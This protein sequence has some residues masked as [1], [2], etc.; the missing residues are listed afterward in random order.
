MTKN[1]KLTL[2][3]TLIL[4]ALFFPINSP[5]SN[6]AYEY[7]LSGKD[8]LDKGD[9]EDAISQL[10][11]AYKKMPGLLDD[12][13]LMWRAE[14]YENRGDIVKALNDINEIKEKYKDSPLI[15]EVRL[16]EIKLLINKNN[17]GVSVLFDS[18]IRDYPSEFD[19]KYAYA[20]FLKENNQ[21]KRAKEIF[22]EIFISAS[23][24]SKNALNRLSPSDIT[25]ED[26]FKRG[27][28]LNNAWFFIE[29]EKYF[30]EAL[31]QK[32]EVR[33][34]R[35]SEEVGSQEAG[36][37]RQ[38]AEIRTQILEGLAYSL[39]RQR[40]Y[41]EA[42]ELYKEMNN[43]FWRARSLF[44]ADDMKGFESELPE[45]KATDDKRF[46]PIF[47]AYGTKKRREGDIEEAL[48]IFNN[49]LSKYPS[50]KEPILWAIGWTHYLS[51]SYKNAH[52]VFFSLH[53]TFGDSK[54]LYWKNRCSEILGKPETIRTPPK[55]HIAHRDFYA[56]LPMFKS[57]P[58]FSITLSDRAQ[59]SELQSTLSAIYNQQ[60][61]FNLPFVTDYIQPPSERVG[62]FIR[63]GFK[64][65][66]IVEL[67]HLS[68]KSPDRDKLIHISSYLK[69]LGEYRK[70][71]RLISR[72]PY[73][74]GFHALL[75]PLAFMAEVENA[76]KKN[77]IDPLLILA[78][79]RE[80]SMLDPNA[81]S[82]AG[83]QGL[84]QLMP[85]TAQRISKYVYPI[86]HPDDLHNPRINILFGAHYL[87]HLID[88]F[89]SI[90]IALAAYNAGGST[91][92]RWLQ[93]GN[94][95]TIDEFIEDIPFRE[96]NTYVKRVLT[97][98]AE[99]M[100]GQ[101]WKH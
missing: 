59:I 65:E 22:K 9:Y 90:P 14:A 64:Q 74:K 60:V 75:Y 83:A 34:S 92:N 30:R 29:A 61:N 101:T 36:V 7:L 25:I 21:P 85:Q 77:N 42:A 70:A 51:E 1:N 88:S 95:N 46:V 84:M 89:N 17:P 23:P 44:R 55:G 27:K 35:K 72:I 15:K 26:I 50:E 81:R 73:N 97:T 3:I 87:S 69:D 56:F 67:I 6:E 41:E 19:I 32:S 39:F 86:K 71:M 28:N 16:K 52:D 40:R 5:A 2:F 4:L 49:L 43:H 76:A 48:K 79:M 45:F 12:Y 100:R 93:R 20:S 24:L 33:R 80:E 58:T 62:I 91:V 11:T 94:Y 98:Y 68:R 10:T 78:V 66:A 38:K 53:K 54:Y 63:L 37:R 82:I 18:F 13:I 8:S 96:T 31:K 57:L 47:I 99:Y